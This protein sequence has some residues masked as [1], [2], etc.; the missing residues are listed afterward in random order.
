MHHDF[1]AHLEDCRNT[2]ELTSKAF[3]KLLVDAFG[4]VARFREK[5]DIISA[6]R[7]RTIVYARQLI[8]FLAKRHTALSLPQ[9]GGFLGGRDHSTIIHAIRATRDRLVNEHKETTQH[10]FRAERLILPDDYL[11]PRGLMQIETVCS[12]STAEG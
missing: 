10:L 12:P 7:Q 6:R 5:P 2:L 4:T 11:E 1:I 3:D 8:A 9:I